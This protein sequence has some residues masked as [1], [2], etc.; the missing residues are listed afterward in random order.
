MIYLLLLFCVGLFGAPVGN[1]TL[2]ALLEEGFL[3]PDTHWSNPQFGFSFDYLIQKKIRCCHSSKSLGLRKGFISG[4]SEIGT[5]VWSIRERFNIQ[6]ELGSGQ[7]SWGWQQKGRNVLG[8]SSGGVLWGGDAKLIILGIKDTTFAIDAQAGGWDWMNGSSTSNGFA[9]GD[10]VNSLLRYWQLG[11]ALTQKIQFFAPYLGF[12]VNRTRLKV[13]HLPT[14]TGRFHARHQIG[15]FGGCSISSGN[16][17]LA[18][19]EWRGWFEEGLSFSAQIR[20]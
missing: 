2:P 6:L 12:A 19:I 9:S 8:R 18:N 1:P 17:F 15:P 11:A 4:A 5:L 16:R 3:I 20:F 13:W 7:Y 10:H 14:G